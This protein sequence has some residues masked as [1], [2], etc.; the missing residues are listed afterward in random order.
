MGDFEGVFEKKYAA[1]LGKNKMLSKSKLVL[2]LAQLCPSL[3]I[4]IYH[5]KLMHQEYFNLISA[6]ICVK[7]CLYLINVSPM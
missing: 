2:S 3:F 1:Y 7:Y 5:I 4:T 6:I